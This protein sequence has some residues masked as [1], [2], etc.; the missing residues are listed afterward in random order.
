MSRANGLNR[1]VT[2]EVLTAQGFKTAKPLTY[3]QAVNG[4]SFGFR[5]IV[6]WIDDMNSIIIGEIRCTKIRRSI[7]DPYIS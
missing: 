7:P 4:N 3:E 5:F 6:E 2:E 1:A